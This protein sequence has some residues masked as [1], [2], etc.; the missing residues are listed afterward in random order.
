MAGGK[1]PRSAIIARH[2]SYREREAK[3]R[4][5]VTLI[6]ENVSRRNKHQDASATPRIVSE[7][8]KRL[9]FGDASYVHIIISI[10]LCTTDSSIGN[11][12]RTS[13]VS[14]FYFPTKDSRK[15]E[16]ASLIG[17]GLDVLRVMSVTSR[18]R[19]ARDGIPGS[20]H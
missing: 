4:R 14:A 20:V 7:S 9:A 6:P 15:S 13:Y 5:C 1:L 2:L 3:Q 11:Q 10:F 16:Q 8:L 19:T 18:Q 17:A 12:Q